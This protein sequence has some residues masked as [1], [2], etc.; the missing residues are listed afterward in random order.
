MRNAML[1][2]MIQN[3]DD[4]WSA[5]VEDLQKRWAPSSTHAS[6]LDAPV[7]TPHE[8][9]NCHRSHRLTQ[10]EAALEAQHETSRSLR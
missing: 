7:L 4:L 10:T 2:Q 8:S 6:E 3:I 5:Y 1:M 9:D